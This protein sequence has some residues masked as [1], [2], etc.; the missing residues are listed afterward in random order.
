MS[1]VLSEIMQSYLIISIGPVVVVDVDES[2]L[3]DANHLSH[4]P[5]ILGILHINEVA[6]LQMSSEVKAAGRKLSMIRRLVFLTLLLP[7]W[8]NILWFHLI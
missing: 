3:W 8:E 2:I 6:R 4:A 5:L 7:V 1:K